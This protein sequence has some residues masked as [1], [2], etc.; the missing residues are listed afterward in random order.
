VKGYKSLKIY[1]ELLETALLKSFEALFRLCVNQHGTEYFRNYVLRLSSGCKS[2][3]L[4]RSH[5]V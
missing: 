3:T 2:I 5:K 1:F 4:R